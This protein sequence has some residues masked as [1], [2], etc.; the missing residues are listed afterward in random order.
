MDSAEKSTERLIHWVGNS[1]LGLV[2]A[3]LWWCKGHSIG[4]AFGLGFA[5]YVLWPLVTGWLSYKTVRALL[6]PPPLA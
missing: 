5:F 2:L 6:R 4:E 1:A 3:L